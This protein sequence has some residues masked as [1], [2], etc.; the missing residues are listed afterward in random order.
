MYVATLDL[1]TSVIQCHTEACTAVVLT[2]V[3]Q[4]SNRVDR[5]YEMGEGLVGNKDKL[6]SSSCLN[7][8][9]IYKIFSI[10]MR[11]PDAP[12]VCIALIL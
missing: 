10:Y 1:L 8:I 5:I 2:A 4:L 7:T 12:L 3:V 6:S 11:T 9:V